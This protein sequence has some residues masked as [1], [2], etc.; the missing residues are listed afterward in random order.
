MDSQAFWMIVAMLL[1]ARAKAVAGDNVLI[2][3]DEQDS[4]NDEL[5]RA[6]A[7]RIRRAEGPGSRVHIDDV[8]AAVLADARAASSP[9]GHGLVIDEAFIDT[10]ARELP[11]LASVL[12]EARELT[13]RFSPAAAESPD[14]STAVRLAAEATTRL[15]SPEFRAI[16]PA[17]STAPKTSS[18]ELEE[19]NRAT[20]ELSTAELSTAELSTAELASPEPSALAPHSYEIHFGTGHFL[21]VGP[22]F[23]EPHVRRLL[24]LLAEHAKAGT[25]GASRSSSAEPSSAEPPP[26][27]GGGTT[28]PYQWVNTNSPVASSRTDDICFLTPKLGWL[29]NSNGQI[30]RTDDGG[31][32]WTIQLSIGPGAN[33]PYMRSI[34]FAND[35][36]GWAGTLPPGSEKISDSSSQ[37][38][39]PDYASQLL[40][41]T[42]D[43]GKNWVQVANLPRN[44]PG[45]MCGL[46][47]VNEKVVYAS[48]SNDPSVVNVGVLKTLDGGET[49]RVIDMSAHATTLIDCHFFDE[50]HGWVVGGRADDRCPAFNPAYNLNHPQY[51]GLKPVVLETRDGGETWVNR[52]TGI[53]FPF[54]GEWGWKIFWLP[55]RQ[56]GFVSLENFG[57]G[58]ILRTDDGGQTW[59]RLPINDNRPLAVPQGGRPI[60]AANANLEGVGFVDEQHGWVGGWG[61]AAFIGN[62]NSYTADGGQTWYAQDYT[63]GLD[64]RRNVNR[65]HFFGNPVNAGFCSGQRV[66]RLIVSNGSGGGGGG[67]AEPD[68][69]EPT[70]SDLLHAAPRLTMAP[71]SAEAFPS[72]A[73]RKH[74]L[75][76]RS[77]HG[78]I[79]AR[80]VLPTAGKRVYLGVWSHFGWFVRTLFDGQDVSA[81]TH[82]FEWD[83]VAESGRKLSGGG[84]L[85][86]LS[87]DDESESELIHLA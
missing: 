46:S 48:G 29:V 77:S 55:N 23:S 60:Y 53:Y 65:Y 69:A 15:A 86:R 81:G 70:P 56:T 85:L 58:G 2:S 41:H 5:I 47:V 50:L 57:A 19:R 32:S 78:K 79:R 14:H 9:T 54:C 11:A 63:D 28:S 44:A 52:A 36:I 10:L 80:F 82:E 51:G 73:E 12:R 39:D 35:Q 87:V 16:T 20:A 45:G 67:G 84:Y 7:A 38:K 21:R 3:L 26:N 31:D 30:A 24:S 40:F 49:W 34:G 42:T 75:Q 66:Y 37:P 74:Q 17:T 59:T 22:T 61:D 83:G 62:Y 76:G 1:R 33:K 64:V 4:T 71:A 27:G 43:G 13:S 68:S 8:V 25:G 72:S 6:A 18:K